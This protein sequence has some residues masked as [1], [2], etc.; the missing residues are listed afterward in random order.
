[1]TFQPSSAVAERVFSLLQNS[2]KVSSTFHWKTILRHLNIVTGQIFFFMVVLSLFPFRLVGVSLE[3]K[4]DSVYYNG[5]TLAKNPSKMAPW[6]PKLFLVGHNGRPGSY[7][8]LPTN[9]RVPADSGH[10]VLIT[11]RIKINSYP[12]LL[13][14]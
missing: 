1:M 13:P 7:C 3:T 10:V 11:P 4:S 14:G 5:R 9:S 6:P 2:F 12:G 8:T